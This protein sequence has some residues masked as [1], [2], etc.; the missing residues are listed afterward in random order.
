MFKTARR[1]TIAA[2]MILAVAGCSKPNPIIGK[3]Q[4]TAPGAMPGAPQQQVIMTFDDKGNETMSQQ[5]GSM[6]ISFV[7][8]YKTENG[9]LSQTLKSAT[10]GGVT[11]SGSGQTRSFPYKIDG[12]TMTL[13]SPVGHGEMVFTRVKE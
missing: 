4:T 5:I 9:Q 2:F 10:I 13:T 1:A 7:S 3:W 11:R 6:S 8:T 12:D